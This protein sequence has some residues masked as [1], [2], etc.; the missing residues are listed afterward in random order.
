MRQPRFLLIGTAGATGTTVTATTGAIDVTGL[1]PS[2]TV[3]GAVSIEVTATIGNIDVTGLTP[4]VL[5]SQNLTATIGNIDV[6]GLI[7]TV[8]ISKSIIISVVGNNAPIVD[9]QG[10]FRVGT[11][12]YFILSGASVSTATFIESGNDLSLNSS[13]EGSISISATYNSGDP[14][15]LIIQ[16]QT[17]NNIIGAYE[18]EVS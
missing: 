5:L 13:G 15:I 11:F 10:N 6:T 4:S 3:G 2:V 8:V 17:D 12:N 9:A 1:T 7:P 18:A 16:D 14:I